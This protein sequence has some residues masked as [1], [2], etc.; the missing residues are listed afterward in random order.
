MI[1][2]LCNLLRTVKKEETLKCLHVIDSLIPH[3]SSPSALAPLALSSPPWPSLGTRGFD[4]VSLLHTE[5]QKGISEPP[6]Q[7]NTTR[8]QHPR[9]SRYRPITNPLFFIQHGAQ[10]LRPRTH[11]ILYQHHSNLRDLSG[12]RAGLYTFQSLSQV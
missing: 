5:L 6:I 12:L 2:K 9:F 11:P 1:S 10:T 3:T 8:P 4:I 7:F